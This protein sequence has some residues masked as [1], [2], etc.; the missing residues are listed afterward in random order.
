MLPV[1]FSFLSLSLS[2]SHASVTGANAL[3]L[4]RRLDPGVLG[5]DERARDKGD[6]TATEEINAR[7]WLVGTGVDATLSFSLLTFKQST[8][9]PPRDDPARAN[10]SERGVVWCGGETHET[11]LH[12]S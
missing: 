7:I 2:H 1:S 11:F 3:L 6:D 8:M 9:D 4:S 10:L 12:L 5:S